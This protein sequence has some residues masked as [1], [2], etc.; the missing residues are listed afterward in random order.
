MQ[1]RKKTALFFALVWILLLLSGCFMRGTEELYCVPKRSDDYLSLQE[2]VEAAIGGGEYCAPISGDN[3]QAIQ[4]A[5][6]NGDGEDEYIVYARTDQDSPLKI[7]VFQNSGDGYALHSTVS[8]EGSAFDSVCYAQIDGTPGMELIVGRRVGDQV[9]QALTVYT[10]HHDEVGELVSTSY[11]DFRI[12]DLDEDGLTDLFVVRSDSEQRNAVAELY[13]WHEGEFARENEANL[14]FPAESY[15]QTA[16]GTLENGKPAFF[17]AGTYDENNIITD[18]LTLT[19]GVF[20]N[21]TLSDESGISTS[22]VRSYFVYSA[23]IDGD[24]ITETPNTVRLPS[25]SWDAQTENQY[26]IVWSTVN[27][28]GKRTEKLRTYHNYADGWY[29]ILP[30]DWTEHMMVSRRMQGMSMGYSFYQLQAGD[31]AE[32]FLSIYAENG[33][34]AHDS[35]DPTQGLVLASWNGISYTV[36]VDANGIAS[37][38][39]G[40]DLREMFRRIVTEVNAAEIG[41][42]P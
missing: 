17:V 2:E 34:D 9:P 23:D 3:R 14:S 37:G 31:K 19:S 6:L 35:T 8:G 25:V 12:K 22:T 38:L 29:L 39:T 16:V 36:Y 28:D 27:E 40:D 5:D 18:I 7:F 13:R 10:F 21:I 41:T 32:R 1:N 4:Q 33:S 15:K 26:V 30:A 20:R 24:G 11:T 42:A